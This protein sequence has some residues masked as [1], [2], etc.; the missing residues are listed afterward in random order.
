MASAAHPENGLPA[1]SHTAYDRTHVSRLKSP[2]RAH[3][4]LTTTVHSLDLDY[5][6]VTTGQT[7]LMAEV[8]EK[9][10]AE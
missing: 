8:S 1:P 5:T 6:E 10:T 2:G 4:Y 7:P 3:A 9:L